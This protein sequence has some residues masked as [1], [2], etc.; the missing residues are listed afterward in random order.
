MP[1]LIGRI[2]VLQVQRRRLAQGAM[3]DP[4]PLLRV[5]RLLVSGRG[6]LGEHDNGYVLDVHAAAYPADGNGR[7][8]LSVGFTAHYELMRSRFDSVPLG[9]AGENIIVES[10]RVF[11]ERDLAGGL[12]VR[13][14]DG[15]FRLEAPKV[16]RPC[17]AFT[18]FLIGD[19][20]DDDHGAARAFLQGGV[21]GFICG[22]E[23]L[24]H[25]EA[26]AIGDEVWLDS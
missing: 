10:N 7:R 6:A 12:V 18:R 16:A 24:D 1:E 5:E 25:Y 13:R 26:V 4:K 11:E 14:S 8:P 20:S 17:A 15:E 19:R 23:H 2:A 22:V 9:I 3:Y 21:R